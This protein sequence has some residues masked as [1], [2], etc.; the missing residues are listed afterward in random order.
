MHRPAFADEFRRAVAVAIANARS[1]FAQDDAECDARAGYA[2]FTNNLH[3]GNSG[4]GKSCLA[5]SLSRIFSIKVIHLDRLFWLPGGYNEKRPENEVRNEIEQKKK[6]NSWIV[7]GVFGELTALFLPRAQTLIYLDMDWPTCRLSL[8]ARGSESSRQLGPAAAEENFKR[9]LLWAERYW[10]RTDLRSHAGHIQ[11]FEG[12][13]GQKFKFSERI[14][15]DG[16]IEKQKTNVN[17]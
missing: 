17:I 2:L 5:E 7:E 10:I 15:V 13:S 3:A 8:V 4:S 9:L 6:D 1:R 14:E 16:F 12:F 11:L